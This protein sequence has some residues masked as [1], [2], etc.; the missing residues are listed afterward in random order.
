MNSK[1]WVQVRKVQ[2]DLIQ[3]LPLAS[4][5]IMSLIVVTLVISI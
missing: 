3:S 1:N 2:P 5:Y 4:F